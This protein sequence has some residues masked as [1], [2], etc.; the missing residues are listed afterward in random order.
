MCY[1]VFSQ[2]KTNS[3]EIEVCSFTNVL[4]SDS[5]ETAQDPPCTLLEN[6]FCGH[7]SLSAVN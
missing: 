2:C 4:T 6:L 1:Q 5:R 3:S 7:M